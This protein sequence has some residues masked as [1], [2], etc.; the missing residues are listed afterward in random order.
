L[1]F[2]VCDSGAGC[3]TA[4]TQVG[5]GIAN[6]RDRIAGVGGTLAVDSA[7]P[8]GTRA[9]GSVPDPAGDE[10]LRDRGVVRI[11]ERQSVHA[12]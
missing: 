7:P 10:P 6:M 5:A 11:V 4:E 9:H 2:T 1:E 3:D 8:R 12:A